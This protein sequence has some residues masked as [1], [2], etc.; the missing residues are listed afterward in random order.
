MNS[1]MQALS[2]STA[3]IHDQPDSCITNHTCTQTHGHTHLAS[4]AVD[5]IC[6]FLLSTIDS[7]FLTVKTN[8]NK[9]QQDK[10]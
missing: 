4:F 3:Q 8:S 5:S 10:W 1:Q 6:T 9:K 2:V 7:P